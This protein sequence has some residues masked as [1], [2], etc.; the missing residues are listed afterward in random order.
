MPT[1]SKPTSSRWMTT[2]PVFL[3][4]CAFGVYALHVHLIA[5]KGGEVLDQN[6]VKYSNTGIEGI[7]NLLNVLVTFFTFSVEPGTIG[8]TFGYT[9][10]ANI[11]VWVAVMELE[12]VRTG[13]SRWLRWTALWGFLYQVAGGGVISSLHA[14]AFLINYPT[15]SSRGSIITGTAANGVLFALAFGYAPSVIAMYTLRRPRELALFQFMPV[16][17]AALRFVYIGVAGRSTNRLAPTK[18]RVIAGYSTT[19]RIFAILALITSYFHIQYVLLPVLSHPQ[20]LAYL[21]ELYIPSVS[22]PSPAL[23]TARTAA[24]HFLQWD[25][26]LILGPTIL[27]GLWDFSLMKKVY[28]VLLAVPACVVLGP[29]AALAGVW[30]YRE[31][32][33][34]VMR[35]KSKE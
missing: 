23:T 12:A 18:A 16:F 24:H 32:V 20:P 21:Q 14:I 6:V 28:L 30:A 29:G 11:S 19:L 26:I 33:M 25:Q 13:A 35:A 9:F 8:R 17:V 10:W 22:I 7:D 3:G 15:P 4:L 31:K 2:A 34:N 1:L 27:A 5:S